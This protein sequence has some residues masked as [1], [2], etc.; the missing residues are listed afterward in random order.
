MKARALLLIL[1]IAGCRER[2]VQ[3][4]GGRAPAVGGSTRILYPS[5]PGSLVD[6]IANARHGVVAIR[7]GTPVK[8]GPAAMFPGA[9]DTL[10][11]VALGTG[12]LIEAK[13]VYV[14]TNDHIAAA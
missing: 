8:S 9:P 5:A 13:G 12:F 2:E 4:D 1:V 3:P 11:D 7:A 14:V 10:A 6:V